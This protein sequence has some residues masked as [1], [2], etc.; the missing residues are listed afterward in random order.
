MEKGLMEPS[1]RLEM[2]RRIILAMALAVALVTMVAMAVTMALVLAM[3]TTIYLL[4]TTMA[5]ALGMVMARN[6]ELDR[7]VVIQWMDLD[8]KNIQVDLEDHPKNPR[9]LTCKRATLK[10]TGNV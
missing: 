3:A 9:V 10:G 5:L 4:A 1:E 8:R 7:T 2:E 6:R